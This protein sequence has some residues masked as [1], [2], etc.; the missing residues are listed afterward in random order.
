M[1]GCGGKGPAQHPTILPRSRHRALLLYFV[2]LR[3][4]LNCVG[5]LDPKHRIHALVSN[6]V[7]TNYEIVL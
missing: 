7:K 2:I 3:T 1:V 5:I 6:P 4:S